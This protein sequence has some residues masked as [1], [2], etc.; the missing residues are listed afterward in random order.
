MD[1][2]LSAASH[3]TTAGRFVRAT[4]GADWSE[5]RPPRYSKTIRVA[6]PVFRLMLV[7]RR[8]SADP[9]VRIR[10]MGEPLTVEAEGT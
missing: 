8:S 6:P 7:R 3:V 4:T 5:A 10:G 1:R 2:P 9:E